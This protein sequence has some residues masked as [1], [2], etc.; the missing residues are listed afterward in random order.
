[1]LLVVG[2]AADISVNF[3][4]WPGPVG[5]M[6]LLLTQTDFHS[7]ENSNRKQNTGNR[8]TLEKTITTRMRMKCGRY[9][10]SWL[11]IHLLATEFLNCETGKRVPKV[12]A[13]KFH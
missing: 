2:T 9:K 3:D 7:G 6:F 5:N 1:M 11:V 13:I 12:G 10:F 4:V 8:R